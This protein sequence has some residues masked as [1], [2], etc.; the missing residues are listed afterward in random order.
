MKLD[1]IIFSLTVEDVQ[2]V[3]EQTLERKL[4]KSELQKLIDPIHENI[5]WFD[6]VQD[7]IL[8]CVK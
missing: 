7:A 6:A 8:S 5:H 2:T 4:S 1:T 3:A